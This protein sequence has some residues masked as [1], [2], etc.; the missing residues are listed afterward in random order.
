MIKKA[1]LI[2]LI[3]TVSSAI[4][5][6]RILSKRLVYKNAQN[7]YIDA[8]QCF[9][10][11][12]NTNTEQEVSVRAF[13]EG[14]YEKD[15]VLDLWEEGSH[16]HI[17]TSFHPDYEV[18][19]DKLSAHKIISASLEI[20]IPVEMT[21][22]LKGT[23]TRTEIEGLYKQLQVVVQDGRCD[24]A[25]VYGVVQVTT[26][27]GEICLKSEEGVVSADTEYGRLSIQDIPLGDAEYLLKSVSGD[28]HVIRITK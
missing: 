20:S 8:Q 24:L 27:T 21:V 16:V 1:V 4:Y 22:F 11:R 6:Q 12:L 23:S 9:K 7:F 28:I 5:G 3:S 2:L 19:N 10:V 15:L 18:K 14:E 26:T 17:G 25:Q 13:V